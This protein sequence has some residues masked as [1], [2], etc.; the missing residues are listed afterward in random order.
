MNLPP[1]LDKIGS[2]N[3]LFVLAGFIVIISVTIGAVFIYDSIHKTSPT[4]TAL[5][6]NENP[7]IEQKDFLLSSKVPNEEH[8]K[9]LYGKI[10]KIEG[11][12]L[13]LENKSRAKVEIAENA[14]FYRLVPKNG[15]EPITK[16]DFKPNETVLAGGLSFSEAADYKSEIFSL[17][18]LPTLL[19]RE[20]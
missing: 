13:I 8:K 1:A 2:R 16:E 15:L 5:N 19:W 4:S 20:E 9:T 10:I 6:P 12:F 17:T 14:R 18:N 3:I 11:N 7:E